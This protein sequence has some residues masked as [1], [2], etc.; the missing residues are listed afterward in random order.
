MGLFDIVLEEREEKEIIKIIIASGP[1][2]PY[3]LRKYGMSEKGCFIRIGSAAE[4][5]PAKMIEN[6][7]AKRTR[8]SIGRIESNQ[9]KLKFEQLKI[10]YDEAGKKLNSRFAT[11]LEFLTQDGKF[12]YV[13]FLMSDVNSL[14]IKVAKYKWL[15]R[16][17]LIE[18]NEYG[19]C[20]II[21]S[22]KQVL[23]KIDLEN[24]TFTKITSKEREEKRLWNAIA[25]R[26]AIINAFVHNDYT[27]E[28][29][30]KFELF[31]DR[32]EITSAGS[33]PDGLSQS[34]FFE[35]CSVPRNQEIM[36]IFKDLDLVENLGSGVPRILESYGKDCFTFS[37]N[38]L[39]MTFP[40]AGQVTDQVTDQVADQ[41]KS[42]IKAMTYEPKGA[43]ELMRILNLKH[44]PTFRINYINPATELK[45]IEMTLPDKPNSRLQKYRLTKKG[46]SLKQSQ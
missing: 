26:E 39:R 40:A 6:L 31:A 44:R 20:S 28:V 41:V 43:I 12:N 24:K 22:A 38:F 46:M 13:A 11:N 30:P 14:S 21:K 18:N 10:Y 9:Q 3:Y 8:N 29:P 2:K 37:D 25:L 1:E 34:E 45:L 23:D 42:L 36:R 7:F 16:V 17:Q 15:S 5:M 32:I 19:Y 27:N 35:G 4:P 33:L